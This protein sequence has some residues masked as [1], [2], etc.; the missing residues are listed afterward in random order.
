MERHLFPTHI[1]VCPRGRAPTAEQ[2]RVILRVSL[3]G[4]RLPF[5]PSRV[6]LLPVIR[7]FRHVYFE[8]NIRLE[9]FLQMSF[10]SSL[11]P[12]IIRNNLVKVINDIAT[13]IPTIIRHKYYTFF[14]V[15]SP[16]LSLI[17]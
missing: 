10:F 14:N 8:F 13:Y 9:K 5:F 17:F 16:K 12:Q 11:M 6:I 1:S 4:S 2:Y 7:H 3:Q 15:I